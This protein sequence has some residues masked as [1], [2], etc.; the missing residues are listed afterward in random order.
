MS[1]H[2]W[3]VP[4]LMTNLALSYS[5]DR[6]ARISSS[7]YLGALPFPDS[8]PLLLQI[9]A[10]PDVDP[11]IRQAAAIT[12][13]NM[14]RK[15][16]NNIPAPTST[17]PKKQVTLASVNPSAAEQIRNSLLNTTFA[18]TIPKNT[19]L[20]VESISQI[21]ISDYPTLWPSLLPTVSTELTTSCGTGDIVRTTNIL[22][23]LRH[24]CKRLEF[25][26]KEE[27]APLLA[28]VAATF[29]TIQ[30]LLEYLITLPIDDASGNMIKQSLKIFWSANQFYLTTN[31]PNLIEPWL[32]I[33]YK[34]MSLP[35]PPHLHPTNEPERWVWWKI[36][37]W[38]VQIMVRLYSRFGNPKSAEKGNEIFASH[39]AENV[40]SRFLQP[41]CELT[42]LRPGGQFCT[43]KVIMLCITY[44]D[45]AVHSKTTY[46]ALKPHLDFVLYQV[47]FP[48]LCLKPDD[49]EK[50]D[51][52]P[53]EY[54]V[55]QNSLMSEYQDIKVNAMSL[56]D[57]LVKARTKQVADKLMQHL[58]GILN[59]YPTTQNHVD[60]D[61]VLL[62][63]TGLAPWLRKQEVYAKSLPALVATQ[64][65]PLFNSPIG[66]LRSRANFAMSGLAEVDLPPDTLKALM[67]SVLKCL[68]DPALPVQIEAAKALRYLLESQPNIVPALKPILH[69]I[70]SAIFAIMNTIG[71]DEV[72][73]SLDII[74]EKFA[75]CIAPHAVALVQQLSSTF[76]TYVGEEDDED[77][78]AAMAATQ[79]LECI[80]TVLRGVSERPDIFKQTEPMLIR[81]IKTIIDEMEDFEY[82]EHALDLLVFLTF[83]QERFCPELWAMFPRV[84]VAFEKYVQERSEHISLTSEHL[85]SLCNHFR[86]GPLPSTFARRSLTHTHARFARRYAADY[87]EQMV[88]PLDNFI[89]KDICN[90]CALTYTPLVEN[91]CAYPA[92]TPYID[93][94]MNLCKKVLSQDPEHVMESDCR[95]AMSLFMSIYHSAK[96]M[97]V[98]TVTDQY[99][100]AVLDMVLIKLDQQRES[101]MSPT[102]VQCYTVIGSLLYYNN[103]L[104]I[105]AL[106]TRNGVSTVFS[107]WLADFDEFERYLSK[108]ATVLGW[109]SV[110]D[111]GS[112]RCKRNGLDL[113]VLVKGAIQMAKSLKEDY[114]GDG[115]SDD[116]DDHG[117]A[118]FVGAGGT[119]FSEY[120]D[121]EDEGGE[122]MGEEGEW[123]DE[124][125]DGDR[126]AE[127]GFNFGGGGLDNFDFAGMG[128]DEDEDDYETP[129]D[130]VR[131]C[132]ILQNTLNTFAQRE[133][134]VFE[135]VKRGLGEEMMGYVAELYQE[136]AVQREEEA[137]ELAK[138][139]A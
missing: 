47:C 82:L 81:I 21:A 37:K 48:A 63:L 105:S 98:V 116:E 72:V 4:T 28:L 36:K 29:P 55:E 42:A 35:L 38:A 93:L 24:L 68:Q 49:I 62:V 108:K 132:I 133:G 70:L 41:V 113:S 17:E 50:F 127:D 124:D 44:L 119:K 100:G 103:E 90:F 75:D 87:L 125:E 126:A 128:F 136:A 112:E 71:N 66:F 1:A 120:V 131:E 26:R 5:A 13:K 111:L 25:K 9:I 85:H 43:D 45:L 114:K 46:V 106:E 51:T 104:T 58:V 73:Q 60:V 79:C 138:V 121:D 40:A 122:G 139:C 115:G 22:I 18:S 123:G 78:E 88:V 56:I 91:E 117:V 107:M 20:L 52:D 2:T 8:P 80:A 57:N 67:E 69:Q 97:P 95:R 23:T 33:F 12:L 19:T 34:L 101:D 92:G 129:L 74:I 31:D 83:Y 99:L 77:G 10:A 130:G 7:T 94:V 27:R 64:I 89:S 16:W 118:S 84:F 102:R 11:S 61:A 6:D 135:E 134:P 54:I 3:D 53:H 14:C 39:F 76:M 96:A 65:L 30:S 109:L 110:L 59:S 32:T 86:L 137:K 15:L